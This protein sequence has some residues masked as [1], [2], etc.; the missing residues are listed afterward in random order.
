MVNLVL[1]HLRLKEGDDIIEKEVEIYSNDDIPQIEEGEYAITEKEFLSIEEIVD[2][3]LNRVLNGE[4]KQQIVSTDENNLKSLQETLGRF[5]RT[6]YGLWLNPHPYS[7]NHNM[8]VDNF[9][10]KISM[11]IIENVRKR[12]I[13]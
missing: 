4:E 10:D 3:L 7:N 2:D 1:T 6:T 9:A 11:M 8:D 5:I 12:L 13:E